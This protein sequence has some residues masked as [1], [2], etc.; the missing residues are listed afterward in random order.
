MDIE[1]SIQDRYLYGDD[2]TVSRRWVGASAILFIVSY[3]F[4]WVP[5]LSEL[6]YN[7]LPID[8]IG[9]GIGLIFL[10]ALYQ[11]Y[12]NDGLFLCWLLIFAP[13]LGATLNHVGVGLTSM[14]PLIAYSLSVVISLLTAVGLG[15]VAFGIAQLILYLEP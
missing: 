13:V 15:T 7:L 14:S 6:G 11:A 1:I 3:V 4:W 10:L 9:G 8:V 2:L 5:G 12:S